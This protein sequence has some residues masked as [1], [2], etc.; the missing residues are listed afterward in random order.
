MEGIEL[1]GTEAAEIGLVTRAVPVDDVDHEVEVL[2]DR[3]KICG[4][5][6]LAYTKLSM[7]KVWETDYRSGLD[8][9][10]EASGMAISAGEF[11]AAV[12]ED[13][14]AGR[15]PTFQKRTRITSGPQWRGTQ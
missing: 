11:T 3:L 10:V 13:F 4:P 5:V 2:C 9:E 12:F 6:A 1:S 14:L 7:N 15:Q 8:Y